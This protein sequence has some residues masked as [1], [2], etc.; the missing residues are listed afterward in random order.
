MS[1]YMKIFWSDNFIDVEG[2]I[3][4]KKLK[5]REGELLWQSNVH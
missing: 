3:G 4:L 1:V 5:V 2:R